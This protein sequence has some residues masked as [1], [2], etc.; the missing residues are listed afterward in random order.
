MFLTP[1]DSSQ[2]CQPTQLLKCS[3]IYFYPYTVSL[4]AVGPFLSPCPQLGE[5]PLGRQQVLISAHLR[6]V[7]PSLEFY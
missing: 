4:H 3:L 6:M 7:L 1:F 5:C 2:L